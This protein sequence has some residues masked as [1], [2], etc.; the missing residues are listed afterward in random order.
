MSIVSVS[1]PPAAAA[2]LRRFLVCVGWSGLGLVAVAVVLSDFLAPVPAGATHIGPLLSAPSA[3]FPFGTD[4]AGRDMFSETLHGLSVTV[5][6]A[7]EAAAPAILAG[8]LLGFMSAHLPRPAGL[9]LRWAIG[10]LAA[11]PALLLA[12]LALGLIGRGFAGIAAGLAVAPLAFMHAFDRAGAAGN[13]VYAGYARAMGVSASTL[14]R[15]DLAYEFRDR[16]VSSAARAFVTVTIV[17]ATVGFLHFGAEPPQRDLGLM[18]SDA[19][20]TDMQAWWTA[21]F[22]ALGLLILILL[23]RLAAGPDEGARP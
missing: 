7:C 15:R 2:F 5:A 16:F 12:I 9:V 21:V 11:V 14:L 13:S 4:L 10:V 17:L 1:A 18:I 8:G 23:A 19:T 3:R 6:Q 22:P 20:A